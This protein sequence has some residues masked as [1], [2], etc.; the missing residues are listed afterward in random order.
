MLV[1]IVAV[2][3]YYAD[4]GNPGRTH[5]LIH[6]RVLLVLLIRAW[7]S[8]CAY[9]YIL[10]AAERTD[11]NSGTIIHTHTNHTRIHHRHDIQVL[12]NALTA[13]P[14]ELILTRS[15]VQLSRR[16]LSIPRVLFL[17]EC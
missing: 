15:S 3:Y 2:N 10:V 11:K 4:P 7:V 6:P 16:D 12:H 5:P 8:L 17:D 13:R 14:I 1:S 9:V